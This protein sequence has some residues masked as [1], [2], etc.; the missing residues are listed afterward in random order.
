[1][2]NIMQTIE[3]ID[4]HFI[5]FRYHHFDDCYIGMTL[6]YMKKKK[7]ISIKYWKISGIEII[8]IDSWPFTVHYI[9]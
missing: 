2:N 5:C 6:R 1:M 8:S 4:K 7:V 3:I 9:S